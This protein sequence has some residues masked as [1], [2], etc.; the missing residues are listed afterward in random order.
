M[1]WFGVL[2]SLVAAGDDGTTI[3]VAGTVRRRLLAAL[4]ARRGQAISPDLLVE[5][6]WGASPPP[7][8]RKTLQ[9]HVVRLRDALGR[10]GGTS[11][12]V[13]DALGY[14][15]RVDECTLDA[16]R[17]E[18]GV[19]AGL[20]LVEDD[21]S[22]A[23][24]ILEDALSLWRAEPYAEFHDAAFA[25]GERI[26][27]NDLRARAVERRV[28]AALELGQPSA[29]V[30]E[31]TART[32]A[33]P[34]GERAWEQLML[35]LYRAGR[36]ADALA[37]YHR[38][39][40][41]LAT[42]LGV[43]PGPVLQNL[44]LQILAREP[45]LRSP[46][47]PGARQVRITAADRSPYPG[48][49]AFAE[50]DAWAFVGRERAV[51]ELTARL[52]S[53]RLVVVTGPSGVGKSSLV[54]AG[55]IPALRAGALPGS[56]AWRID[57]VRPSGLAGMSSGAALLVVD[58]AEELLSLADPAAVQAG[59]AALLRVIEGDGRVVLVVRGD[60]YGRLGELPALGRMVA[61]GTY[62]LRAMRGDDLRRAI[63]QPAARVG[64]TVEP[65]LVEA[66]LDD[67]ATATD[68]LPLAAAAL[69]RAWAER[70]GEALTLKAY[71]SA[72][73]VRG[74]LVASA[75][76]TYAALSPTARR[77]ARQLLT[78]LATNSGG[79]WIALSMPQE[80]ARA[81]PEGSDV[82]AGL[83]SG[84][85][86]TL[87]GDRVR[88]THEV[89]LRA[90]PRLA[91]WL[92]QR[93]AALGMLEHV[94]ALARTW[95]EDG[96]A[97][98]DVLRGPR[99]T[100]ALD[101]VA[102]HPEDITP[103]EAEFLD[104]CARVSSDEAERESARA[105]REATGR[106]RATRF[107]RTAAI[108]LLAALVAL[109]VG[110]RQT[111]MADQAAVT[112]DA[113]RLVELSHT[114]DDLSQAAT[115]AL[116][117]DQL[118]DSTESRGAL[119]DVLQRSGGVQWRLSATSSARDLYAAA[120]RLW[121]SDGDRVVHVVEVAGP[122][123]VA[124][125]PERARRLV[126]VTPDGHDVI[127]AGPA[128]GVVDKGGGGRI[129]VLDATT[130][131]LV[132]VL[133]TAGVNPAVSFDST[134]LTGDGHWL[135][136]ILRVPADH[137]HLTVSNQLAI[138]DATNW[139]AA[140]RTVRLSGPVLQVRSTRHAVVA[141]S[142]GRLAV[143]DP[144][145]GAITSTAQLAA[146][147]T[148]AVTVEDVSPDAARAA[149]VP[150]SDGTSVRLVA[151]RER[152]GAPQTLGAQAGAVIAV[153]VS[154][155]GRLIGIASSD[156]VVTVYDL[157][158]G[159]P[160]ARLHTDQDPVAL[161]WQSDPQGPRLATVDAAG[162]VQ[163]WQ[164]LTAQ[165]SGLV[166]APGQEVGAMSTA[167][168]SGT[169]L[170]G[171]GP[172]EYGPSV[173]LRTVDLRTGAAKHYPLGLGPVD[174]PDLLDVS[175]DHSRALVT[176][177]GTSGHDSWQLWDLVAGR[178][179]RVFYP[180]DPDQTIPLYAALSPG[181]HTAYAAIDATTVGVLDLDSGRWTA[182]WRPVFA[183]PGEERQ[184]I[185]PL[186][187][188]TAGRLLVETYD[189]G[190]PSPA[191]PGQP[192]PLGGDRSPVNFRVGLV[193]LRSGRLVAEAGLGP[194]NP[195]AVNPSAD[196]RLIAVGGSDGRVFLLDGATLRRVA[197][198]VT[199]GVG[200][201][202]AVSV[203]PDDRTVVSGSG[204]GEL[205]LWDATTLAPI[206][207]PVRAAEPGATGTWIPAWTDSQTVAGLEPTGA[208]EG[209][210]WFTMPVGRAAW[211][212]SAC[213]IAGST[214]N[215]ATWRSL[216]G[217]RPYAAPCPTGR[218]AAG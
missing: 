51:A 53:R 79:S 57:L 67:V 58:G 187:V 139:A 181:G 113:R 218:S 101:W 59:E 121:V 174:G 78:R 127:V 42:E 83:G 60:L 115:A 207:G 213:T 205:R 88:L 92:A 28:D 157:G 200:G 108:G 185:A 152:F 19:D 52:S 130:G 104:A 69:R 96:R 183:R 11:I 33:E 63:E 81:L 16:V 175:A 209:Q 133:T 125:Y 100:A 162:T 202:A 178:R 5:D 193:D 72:G 203:A 192:D 45:S 190:P 71:E 99:L 114:D 119:L 199:A 95:R 173:A 30:A 136:T 31:L 143:V 103:D 29:L 112:A 44:Q 36:P 82:L 135:A 116:V 168:Q 64:L 14:R 186:H 54:A 97:D 46:R 7:S 34:F 169:L 158:T 214:M 154:P 182:R 145:R 13:T 126:A 107:A 111:V 171:W 85:I 62:L 164:Q 197:G 188:D 117:A 3:P 55:L 124:T 1:V 138:F 149:V 195:M 156:R 80:Q 9:S 84:R 122:R 26:R 43:D 159:R 49:A 204:N 73:G 90:W 91:D 32:A 153:R 109:G 151:L 198:P 206:G 102:D 201:I 177:Q 118:Q 128:Y 21:P 10:A 194:T 155:N 17:F 4:L 208:L 140:P 15:L 146:D 75:E 131:A 22:R 161:A 35:A 106:R 210:R 20:A 150:A 25:I 172:G 74:A 68:A 215:P 70:D 65:G 141:M 94:A 24:G 176:I 89:V 180:P 184:V 147:L 134:V 23:V 87:D 217:D 48:L 50:Q 165:A 189:P 93:E 27:L 41:V 132:R 47:A 166:T 105:D 163:M 2:G 191:P 142:R 86:V 179:L 123:V 120:G 167:T 18:L 76:E 40:S 38:A 66:V 110:I 56:A 6:L 12:V 148:T 211:I 216:V 39:R 212:A 196:S 144:A 137:T 129:S 77:S 98:V 160:V 170:V 8:A 61:D 37:T